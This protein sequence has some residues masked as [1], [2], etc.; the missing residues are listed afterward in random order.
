M[1]P[2]PSREWY[3]YFKE[4]EMGPLTETVLQNKVA[5]GELDNTA[6]VF[7]E[8]MSDWTALDEVEF[9]TQISQSQGVVET[10]SPDAEP[11]RVVETSRD[12]L[13]VEKVGKETLSSI[14]ADTLSSLEQ[15]LDS[16]VQKN[17][18]SRKPMMLRWMLI[19]FVMLLLVG[20][21]L[22]YSKM[23][24]QL[25]NEESPASTTAPTDSPNGD[26]A[27]S[28]TNKAKP[29][30][31]DVIWAEL[32]S[33]RLSQ[34]R[35]GPPF[36]L[37]SVL[38]SPDR[39][40]I[41]GAVSS[42]IKTDRIQLVVYPDLARSLME[43]PRL[44]WFD[45][46]LVDGYFVIGPLNIEGAPLPPG[47]Y[48]VM[49]QSMG[50]YMGTVSFEVGNFPT[51]PDLDVQMKG[52]Q[53][54]RAMAAAEE[55]KVLEGL[56]RDFDALYES[57]RRDVVR[58]AIRGGARRAAWTKAMQAWTVAFSRT[59][60]QLSDQ[61]ALTFYP[62]LR[63]RLDSL[64]KELVK[65]QGLM[66]FYS[67]NGRAGFEK[68]AGRR[69]TEIWNSL[70]KDRDFLKS[71]FLAQASQTQTEATLDEDRLKTRLLEKR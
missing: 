57:L 2:D 51:G 63:T 71:E 54:Q 24:P 7:T 38:L 41:T 21:L 25:K 58:F 8:G 68:R 6:F 31:L 1:T 34:D 44:W 60:G 15:K 16:D 67:Q 18:A 12:S 11:L 49:A 30:D 20:L 50:K 59:F 23:I 37:S 46:S 26:A 9:L 35:Q 42:L 62:E 10:R 19:G 13:K 64:A 36:R 70:Q 5:D 43:R 55:L 27:G 33:L 29:S 3:V 69:Y 61:S 65:V 28:T 53:N 47:S 40:I 39:P 56:F 17:K 52:L 22:D 32:S 4:Q 45:A 66:D 48:K 14:P